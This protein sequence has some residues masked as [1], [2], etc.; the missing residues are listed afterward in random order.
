MKFEIRNLKFLTPII[1]SL[2]LAASAFA[3]DVQLKME[4]QLISLMDRA[5]LKIEFIDTNGDAPAIPDIDGLDIRYQG[6]SSQTQ[7]I[8]WKTTS[9]VI[10]SYIVT[11]AK[12]G[13]FTIGPIECKYKG[14]KKELTAQLRVIK[15]DG[16]KEAQTI[17]DMLFSRIRT[18]KEKPFVHEPFTLFL[19][20]YAK[21][22][23]QLA[24]N[25]SFRGGI[26]E[27]GI[28][29]EPEWKMTG[30]SREVINGTIYN[31]HRLQGRVETLTAGTFS[32]SPSIQVNVVVPREKRRSHGFDDAFFGDFFGRQETRP[33]VLS[34]NTQEV[35]VQPIP[36]ERR[37]PSYT[38][39]IGKFEFEVEVSPTEVKAGEP[40]TVKMRISGEGNLAQITAPSIQE[41]PDIKLYEVRS[42]PSESNREIRFEQ[43]VIPR[44]D[45]VKE[46]PAIS[47][48]YFNALTADYRTITKGPFP[49]TVTAA[50]S[51]GA[52]VIAVIPTDAENKTKILGRDIVYLKSMPKRWITANG[53]AW[54][55]SKRFL[56]LLVLPIL[57]LAVVFMATLKRDALEVDVARARRHKAPKAARK[58]IQQVEHA[59]RKKDE[60]AFY[61]ALW[62]T[63]TEYFGNRLNLAAGEVSLSAVLSRLPGETKQEAET[64]TML[65]DRIEQMRYGVGEPADHSKQ[66]MKEMLAQT[67]RILKR[68]ERMKL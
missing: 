1:G 38:G 58:N 46:I 47:F 15:P 59:I 44:S 17:S 37:P 12:T 24:G 34:C 40:V 7:M 56:A 43:V 10:H 48:S 22:G 23:L 9:K 8:N 65:F 49:V 42:V 68:C 63:L 14:G 53:T 52:Q 31:V 29:G 25:I 32:F 13:D 26:P 20:I 30:Q 16:D 55:F 50:E 18:D 39:G 2:F 67:T 64:L 36:L 45:N 27:T 3:A 57:L 62:K 11:P 66:E 33:V 54:Y 51:Q 19:S 61:E 41:N 60:P 35:D 28:D 6:K 4:P 5:V 21:E